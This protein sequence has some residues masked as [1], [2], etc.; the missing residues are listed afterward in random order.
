MGGER[1]TTQIPSE[2]L[3]KFAPKVRTAY[4]EFGMKRTPGSATGI[5]IVFGMS[6]T[7]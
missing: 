2:Q 4:A 3:E 1:R 7:A 6:I 5:S